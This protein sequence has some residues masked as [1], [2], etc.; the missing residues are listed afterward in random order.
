MKIKLSY[1]LNEKSS[2][3][4]KSVKKAANEIDNQIKKNINRNI[5]SKYQKKKKRWSIKANDFDDLKK[6]VYTKAKTE[7]RNQ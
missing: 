2:A 5:K 7:F 1:L 4:I 3:L 6:N